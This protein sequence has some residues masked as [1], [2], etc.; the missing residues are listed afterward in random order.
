MAV[1]AEQLVNDKYI[2]DLIRC[3]AKQLVGKAGF[4][5]DDLRDLKQELWTHLIGEIRLFDPEKSSLKTFASMLVT[6][7]VSKLIRGRC[8]KSRDFR[9]N[10]CSLSDMVDDGTGRIVRRAQTIGAKECEAGWGRAPLAPDELGRLRV[11]LKDQLSTLPLEMQEVC[12]RLK[13]ESLTE[14]AR[15]MGIPLSTLW[16]RLQKVRSAFSEA[17]FAEYL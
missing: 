8:A 15:D 10:T 17:G 4:K 1:T 7:K 3:K 5:A 2:K 6:Q 14:I 13:S 12:E 11:D 9:R 16:G